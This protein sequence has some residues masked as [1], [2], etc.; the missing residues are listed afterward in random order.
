MSKLP[1]YLTNWIDNHEIGQIGNLCI[2]SDEVAEQFQIL[3]DEI[4]QLREQQAKRF[5]I[6]R[7][8]KRGPYKKKPIRC[9]CGDDVVIYAGIDKASSDTGVTPA[10]IYNC[11]NNRSKTAGGCEWEYATDE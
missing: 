11:L 8:T 10:A 5:Q 2:P 9:T 7:P 1:D 3:V 4:E 6:A